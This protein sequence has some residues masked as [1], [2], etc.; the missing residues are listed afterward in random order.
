MLQAHGRASYVAMADTVGLTPAAV[1]RRVQRLIASSAVRIGGLA[2]HSGFSGQNAT[3]A[4]IRVAGA[5][6]PVVDLLL[7]LP[8]LLLTLADGRPRP[9]LD[10]LEQIRAL[11]GVRDLTTWQ[12]AEIVKESYD[13]VTISPRRADRSASP[14]AADAEH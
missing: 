1:R 9:V 8:D 2:R 4:A 14:S 12:H 11:P 10:A 3:G 13:A 5:S 7:E 6:E